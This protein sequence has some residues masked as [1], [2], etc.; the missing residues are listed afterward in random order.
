M[1]YTY[2]S[3]STSSVF[4][5]CALKVNNRKQVAELEEQTASLQEQLDAALERN[6]KLVVFRQASSMAMKKF[7]EKED[8][9]SHSFFQYY[10]CFKLY[11]YGDMN[12]QLS[13]L[14]MVRRRS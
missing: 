9:V 8:E 14:S 13:W 2:E 12:T 4:S 3:G 5:F 11:I 1:L 6:A 7:R 10:R